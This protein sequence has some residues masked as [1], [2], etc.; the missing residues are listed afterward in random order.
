MMGNSRLYNKSPER[1]NS[2][3]LV[4]IEPLCDL[5]IKVVRFFFGAAPE[6]SPT[7]QRSTSIEPFLES[8][9]RFFLSPSDSPAARGGRRGVGICREGSIV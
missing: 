8:R 4:V 9:I 6:P 3:I 1:R 2:T 5:R 7:M